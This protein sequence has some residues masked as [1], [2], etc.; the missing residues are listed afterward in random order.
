MSVQKSR[1][2]QRTDF[3]KIGISFE[4][5]KR[6]Q[7]TLMKISKIGVKKI[8]GKF[9]RISVNWINKKNELN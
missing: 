2:F 5:L 6:I 8:Q 9:N 4:E 1:E 3:S 7:K